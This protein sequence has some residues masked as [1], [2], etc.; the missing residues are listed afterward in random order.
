MYSPSATVCGPAIRTGLN[1]RDFVIAVCVRG[2]RKELRLPFGMYA[3]TKLTEM[4]PGVVTR[5]VQRKALG[6]RT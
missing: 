6:V 1:R 3:A 5:Q 4:V 2:I